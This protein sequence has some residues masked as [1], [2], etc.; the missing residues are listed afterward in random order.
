VQNHFAPRLPVAMSKAT[1]AKSVWLNKLS[2][3]RSDTRYDGEM[4]TN[5]HSSVDDESIEIAC[6]SMGNSSAKGNKGGSL[7]VLNASTS[8]S[9]FPMCSFGCS[10]HDD[11]TFRTIT[12]PLANI[13]KDS[14]ILRSNHETFV[15][16]SSSADNINF[17]QNHQSNNV[18]EAAGSVDSLFE[19]KGNSKMKRNQTEIPQREIL[20]PSL[21]LLYE[22]YMERGPSCAGVFTLPILQSEKAPLPKLDNPNG[23]NE[24]L[25]HLDSVSFRESNKQSEYEYRQ[26]MRYEAIKKELFDDSTIATFDQETV[27]G[28]D[29]VDI[30]HDDSIAAYYAIDRI[31]CQAV[32]LWNCIPNMSLFFVPTLREG[33]LVE[34]DSAAGRDSDDISSANSTCDVR[35]VSTDDNCNNDNE[36]LLELNGKI[37]SRLGYSEK[38]FDDSFRMESVSILDKQDDSSFTSSFLDQSHIYLMMT[39]KRQER[40]VSNKLSTEAHETKSLACENYNKKVSDL[41]SPDEFDPIVQ[42]GTFV[43]VK[44]VESNFPKALNVQE[45]WWGSSQ[46]DERTLPET[47]IGWIRHFQSQ[48]YPLERN[49]V[50]NDLIQKRWL[51][52]ISQTLNDETGSFV[53]SSNQNERR[54][55][56]HEA[57]SR[58]RHTA[59]ERERPFSSASFDLWM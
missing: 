4:E 8:F 52:L 15:G 58:I 43:T 7:Q 33:E 38:S 47:S 46:L 14:A 22:V 28:F 29:D 25:P 53:A 9:S 17:M 10:K 13:A 26:K 39:N 55:A 57:L 6:K 36:P 27:D 50:E 5:I 51:H 37:V 16:I 24:I 56:A 41:T 18:N 23:N 54:A 30:Y 3:R 59:A 1:D 2:C 21:Q 45:S 11:E 40:F 20:S 32:S 49:Q 42:E 19:D 44:E 48:L 34:G 12:D 35:T 31:G